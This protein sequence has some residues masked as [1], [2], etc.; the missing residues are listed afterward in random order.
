MISPLKY[1]AAALLLNPG[2]ESNAQI[3]SYFDHY[4]IWYQTSS[5]TETTGDCELKSAFVYYIDGD[6][7][8]VASG[9]L[10]KRIRKRGVS[11]YISLDT[12]S[13]VC[14]GTFDFHYLAALLRQDGQKI[15]MYDVVYE[16]DILLWDF[17]LGVGDTLP[18]TPIQQTAGVVVEEIDSFLVGTE[19]IHKFYISVPDPEWIIEGIGSAN[20]LI[21]AM[22]PESGCSYSG[23]CLSVNGTT[24]WQKSASS[25]C[26]YTVGVD[27]ESQ[28]YDVV[29]FP[30]PSSGEFFISGLPSGVFD[31]QVID[32]SG[33]IVRSEIFD[34][35]SVRLDGLSNGVWL[36]KISGDD[37]IWQTRVVRS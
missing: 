17:S 5:C 37:F 1:T 16:E 8:I 31:V 26:L 14:T 6:T 13:D 12:S 29:V 15:Y 11:E 33:R 30:N 20:G 27:D 32:A 28:T 24:V 21:E 10:Y 25:A 9:Q 19:Y 3:F 34:G 22:V 36:L 18:L 7:D 2:L 23:E 4:Q 35:N